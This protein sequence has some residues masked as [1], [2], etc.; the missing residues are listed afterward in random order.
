MSSLTITTRHASSGPRYVVRYRL[1]GRTYPVVHGG[2]FKTLRQAKTRRDLR[3]R[4]RKLVRPPGQLG[5][6][7]PLIQLRTGRLKRQV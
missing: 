3:W 2:S 6:R 1:G 7:L 4:P 5:E